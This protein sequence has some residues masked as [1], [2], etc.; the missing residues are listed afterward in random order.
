M[1]RGR[2]H[3]LLAPA[4]TRAVRDVLRSPGKTLFEPASHL[5]ESPGP[6]PYDPARLPVTRPGGQEEQDA[7]QAETRPPIGA[8]FTGVR[9]HTDPR[10]AD[11]ARAIGARAYTVGRHVVFA[12]GEFAPGRESG[13]RLLAHELAHVR[14]PGSEQRV[15]REPV[16]GVETTGIDIDRSKIETAGQGNY[17]EQKVGEKFEITYFNTVQSRFK[18]DTEE[19]DAVLSSVW[20]HHPAAAVKANTDVTASIPKRPSA[21]ASK[22]VLYQ[23]TFTPPAKGSKLEGVQIRLKAEDAA[24]L[25]AQAQTPPPGYTPPSLTANTSG[26]PETSDKYFKSHPDEHKQLYNWIETAP[27][28]FD[29][30]ITTN[31]TGKGGKK[32]DSSFQV[33]GVKDA[34]GSL[35]S[36]DIELLRET[37][38]FIDTPPPG[39]HN[40]DRMDLDLEKEQAK[41]A[42]KLG[43]ISGLGTLPADE[44]LS[45]KYVVWQYFEGGTRNKEV[46]VIIPIAHK[47]VRVF[48]TIRFHPDHND[49]DVERVGE[50]G[51]SVKLQTEALNVTRVDGFAANSKDATSFSSWIKTRYPSVALSGTSLTDLQDSVNKDMAANAGTPAW[52]TKNYGIE[53]LDDTAAKTRLTTVH[54]KDAREADGLKVFDPAE[55]KRL[56]FALETM[57]DA[58]LQLLRGVQFARQDVFHKVVGR[59]VTTKP[60]TTGLTVQNG[61]ERT[62]LIYN[63]VTMNDK[64]LFAGGAGGVRQADVETYTHELGH[65]LGSQAGIEAAYTAF[66]AKKKIKPITWYAASDP[67]GESFP[68]AFSLYKNDPEWMKNNLPDLFTWFETVKTTGKPPITP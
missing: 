33:K 22:Q 47:T 56:E 62:I 13:R 58:E 61:S 8:D 49:V 25:A 4:V 59:T 52:F 36:L 23:F 46:D 67:G 32:H 6:E 1:S 7:R 66:V 31:E 37:P 34:T 3:E 50:E 18:A 65:A 41:A 39:Y 29:Q 20:Q 2:R 5:A 51:S 28:K 21:P 16:T 12:P 30:I 27:A 53:I 9:V 35:T 48:Y 57:S 11:S 15:A 42:N 45:V 60:K 19:R 68:E 54:H 44:Q 14:Q 55:L 10:A 24:A 38:T 43:T 26:F 40:K 63:S 64:A 17:W